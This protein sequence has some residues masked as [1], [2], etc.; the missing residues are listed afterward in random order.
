MNSLS[1][2][3]LFLVG[4]SWLLCEVCVGAG[5]G[6]WTPV[7]LFL[8]GF[9]VMFAIMGCLPV[10]EKAI[11][12][13]GPIFTILIGAGIAYYGIEELASQVRFQQSLAEKLPFLKALVGF[14]GATLRLLGAGTLIVLGAISFAGR[15]KAAAH[16]H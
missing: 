12:T 8:A 5:A 10:S 11:N 15:E 16:S 2:G 1:H 7:W 3:F 6:Y 14:L 9:T 4:L 13:A